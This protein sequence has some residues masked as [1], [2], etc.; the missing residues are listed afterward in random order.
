MSR[1]AS[2]WLRKGIA[3]RVNGVCYSPSMQLIS[4]REAVMFLSQ[5]APRPWVQRLLRWMAFDDEI[6]AYSSKGSVFAHSNV[7]AFTAQLYEEAGESSGPSMDAAIVKNYS[8]EMAA[9]LVG[10]S[11]HDDILDDP[12]EWHNPTDP[13]II[14]FGFFLYGPEIDWDEGKIVLDWFEISGSLGESIF[15]DGEM[16]GTEF[17]DPHYSAIIEGLSFPFQQIELLLPN[18]ELRKS[19]GFNAESRPSRKAVGRP[20]KWDWE[21]ALAFVISNAQTPDGLPTGQGAQAR[22]E[23]L[24]SGWFMGETGDAPAASQIRQRASSIMRMLET[25]KSPKIE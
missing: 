22:L 16:F 23:E 14:P 21:G 6:K 8:P 10:K 5:A 1:A 24:I 15:P 3:F 13:E 19:H 9:K 12:Y 11:Q 7:F 25:S 4:S 2:A 17:D 20:P 18:V